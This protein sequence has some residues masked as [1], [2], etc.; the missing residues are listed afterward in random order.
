MAAQLLLAL[1]SKNVRLKPLIALMSWPEVKT[2]RVKLWC[3]APVR[4]MRQL[5]NYVAG[6]AQSAGA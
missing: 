3:S 6:Y 1:V 2:L 5:G 4:A